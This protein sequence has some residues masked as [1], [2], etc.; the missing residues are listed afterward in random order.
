MPPPDTISPE[1]APAIADWIVQEAREATGIRLDYSLGSLAAVDAILQGFHNR[2]EDPAAMRSLLFGFG[3]YV[4][5]VIRRKAG[6]EWRDG[7]AVAC[8]DAMR[9]PL[10]LVHDGKVA[11][12][13]QKVAARVLNGPEDGIPFYVQALTGLRVPGIFPRRRGVLSRLL[14]H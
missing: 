10:M 7:S 2:Q 1:T 8:P 4:G 12:P 14:D 9:G 11:N 6:G 13:A 5:E 3:V